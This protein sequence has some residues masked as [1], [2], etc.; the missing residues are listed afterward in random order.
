MKRCSSRAVTI[1]L[2]HTH[3]QL[4]LMVQSL[5]IPSFRFAG[6]QVHRPLHDPA[7]DKYPCFFPWVVA[8]QSRCLRSIIGIY[9]DKRATEVGIWSSQHDIALSEE[10][11]H[12]S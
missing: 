3:R 4:L 9:Y 12:E 2:D 5:V 11:V 8:K 6:I 10:L 7:M 1:I